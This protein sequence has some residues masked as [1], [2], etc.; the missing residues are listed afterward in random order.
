LTAVVLSSDGSRRISALDQDVP[1]EW[2]RLAF[3][4]ADD[5]LR[6]GAADLIGS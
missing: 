1:P 2:E 4:V 5:L 3:R 6:Q